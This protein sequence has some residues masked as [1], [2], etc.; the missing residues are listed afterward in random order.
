MKSDLLAGGV[1]RFTPLASFLTDPTP[2]RYYAD[3]V[4]GDPVDALI[5]ITY[6]PEASN[7]SD[8]DN[9]FGTVVTLDVLANDDGDFPAGYSPYKTTCPDNAGDKVSFTITVVGNGSKASKT[10]TVKAQ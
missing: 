5:T 2:I 6:L 3:D 9:P 8:L 7:D 1:I 4:T 10:A